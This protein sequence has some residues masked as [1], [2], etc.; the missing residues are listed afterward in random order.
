M[1]SDDISLPDCEKILTELEQEERFLTLEAR[2]KLI[3]ELA[4]QG[5][6][7]IEKFLE[8]KGEHD[9]KFREKLESLRLKL[10]KRAERFINKLEIQYKKERELILEKYS[11]LYRTMDENLNEIRKLRSKIDVYITDDDLSSLIIDENTAKLLLDLPEEH[12]KE[13]TFWQKIREFFHNLWLK[14]KLF[15]YRLYLKI[16]GKDKKVLEKRKEK[17]ILLPGLQKVFKQ[18]SGRIHKALLRSPEYM[19]KI[20]KSLQNEHGYTQLEIEYKKRYTPEEYEKEAKEILAKRLEKEIERKKEKMLDEK[21][22][23]EKQE[24]KL[25]REKA[26]LKKRE[27]SELKR[28][29]QDKEKQIRKKLDSI[30]EETNKLAEKKIEEEL[31]EEGLIKKVGDSI[32][33]TYTLIERLAELL[34]EEELEK[35]PGKYK[36]PYRGTTY[37]TGVYEKAK[38]IRS[39]EI[40][41]I[42]ITGSLI[43]SRLRGY[44]S[45]S[46]DEAYIYREIYGTSKHVVILFDKSGSMAENY[47]LLAAKKA[48]MALYKAIIG[49][50]SGS[51]VDLVAF[52]N[53]VQILDLYQVWHTEPGDFTNT[54]EALKVAYNTLKYSKCD[55]KYIYLIT[56]GLPEAYTNEKNEVVA[57]NFEK[58]L[59]YA[60][61]NATLLNRIKNLKFTIILLECKDNKFVNAA[62]Q[63]VSRVGGNILFADPTNLA[64]EMLLDLSKLR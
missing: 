42:D 62:E 16:T 8:S 6:K 56:D 7:G 32:E 59:E 3:R 24:R 4:H 27:E 34:L 12:E 29:A 30:E 50:A 17:Y 10:K 57:G 1:D 15:F 63:I 11:S 33:V 35:L 25:Q 49:H 47:R 54:G 61:L 2:A 36:A 40:D 53:H 31:L 55:V 48:A 28:I 43:Q 22:N 20:D 9:T 41:R 60:L 51:I 58:S 39:E 21:K 52:D 23:L 18:F 45:L 37:N 26:D 14:I 64:Y 19:K 38:K 5:F 44:S 46:E 13:K